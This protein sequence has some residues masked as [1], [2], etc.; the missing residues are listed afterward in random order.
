MAYGKRGRHEKCYQRFSGEAHQLLWS[1]WENCI[2][3]LHQENW[4]VGSLTSWIPCTIKC[5]GQWRKQF[6]SISSL[7]ITWV[8]LHQS[9]KER[10][11]HDEAI[12]VAAFCTKTIATP[13]AH[14]FV[15]CSKYT[16]RDEFKIC[17]LLYINLS[18][19]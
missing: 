13:G 10:F 7:K 15:I 11:R 4:F 14:N 2:E 3:K 5:R 1:C 16:D 8:T 9:N 6:Y 17:L 12:L 19:A 18:R